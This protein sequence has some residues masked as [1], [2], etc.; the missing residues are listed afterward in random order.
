MTYSSILRF[1]KL[2]K[3]ATTVLLRKIARID[4]QVG[5][6][7]ELGAITLQKRIKSKFL[8]G[9]QTGQT[10]L[11]GRTGALE[12]SVIIERATQRGRGVV[13]SVRI[14]SK[15]AN[16]HFGR[17]GDVTIIRPKS[18]KALTI[19]T[20]HAQDSRGATLGPADSGR[21]RDTFI[22]NGIIFGRASSTGGIKPLFILA[23]QV[24]VPVRIDIQDNILRPTTKKLETSLAKIMR[25]F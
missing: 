17:K 22:K 25:E 13:S 8:G 19:P 12:E 20:P 3:D 9:S 2:A 15:Y 10:R 5:R 23:S 18:K 24:R 14:A 7:L 21:F 11:K 6:V 16:V 1:I 4:R